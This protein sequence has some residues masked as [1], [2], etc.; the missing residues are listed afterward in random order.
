[1]LRTRSVQ[2]ARCPS[3]SSAYAMPNDRAS[4]AW[5]LITDCILVYL[6]HRRPKY[7]TSYSKRHVDPFL[8]AGTHS[9]GLGPIPMGRGP[10]PPV[11]SSDGSVSARATLVAY[12]VRRTGADGSHPLTPGHLLLLS[13]RLW[14][15]PALGQAE[16]AGRTRSRS[17]G[18]YRDSDRALLDYCVELFA[19][20]CFVMLWPANTHG[21][22][23]M[24][25][26]YIKNGEK[27][28][29]N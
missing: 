11:E 1:M 10:R 12:R 4:T 5:S 17:L 8:W 18:R 29:T 3:S 24:N 27:S 28:S 15:C 26:F 14:L 13:I 22:K 25:T 19:L 9:Y 21:R 2:S 16:P 6:C 7:E 23:S 20:L